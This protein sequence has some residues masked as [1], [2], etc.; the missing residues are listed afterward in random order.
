LPKARALL[1]AH[2]DDVFHALDAT[3]ELLALSPSAVELIDA[4]TL[5]CTKGHAGYEP[6]R[7]WVVGEPSAVQVVEFFA[8]AIA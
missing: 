7:S 8:R 2:F 1:V 6:L 4:P 5:N 3:P